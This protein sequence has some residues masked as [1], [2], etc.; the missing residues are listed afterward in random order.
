MEQ[1]TSYIQA[2]DSRYKASV[3]KDIIRYT[4]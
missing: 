1:L 4:I 2:K 3:Q